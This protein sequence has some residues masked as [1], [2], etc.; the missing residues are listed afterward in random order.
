M[1]QQYTRIV[2]DLTGEIL[3]ESK[4][5]FMHSEDIP[6]IV[7]KIFTIC[8]VA[9][10]DYQGLITTSEGAM[11]SITGVRIY[12]TAYMLSFHDP[13]ERKPLCGALIL[14]GQD[15][16]IERKCLV[17]IFTC[18]KEELVKETH[19]Y[20][21]M[22]MDYSIMSNKN[23]PLIII[24]PRKDCPPMLE[25]RDKDIFAMFLSSYMEAEKKSI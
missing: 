10:A 1:N 2:M 15:Q 9:G 21:L 16:Q 14:T 19:A 24:T 11:F 23:R 20:E 6:D 25:D 12:D 5:Q 3:E 17:S 18:H 13:L 7:K 22:E 4:H 8:K